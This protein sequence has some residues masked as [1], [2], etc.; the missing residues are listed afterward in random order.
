VPTLGDAL[1][2]TF[3]GIEVMVNGPDDVFVE[4]EGRIEGAR[5]LFEGEEPVLHLIERNRWTVGPSRRRVVT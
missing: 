5:R 2:R 4:R 3:L 1:L